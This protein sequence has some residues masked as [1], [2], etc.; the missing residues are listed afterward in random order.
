MAHSVASPSGEPLSPVIIY[1]M[2]F[3]KET[4][5]NAFSILQLFEGYG[6][7]SAQTISP[8]KCK[9]FVGASV[10]TTRLNSPT[11]IIG[12]LLAI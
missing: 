10:F 4:Q 12:F 9:I 2:I 1:L 11:K 3:C 8:T 6:T 5:R 7:N